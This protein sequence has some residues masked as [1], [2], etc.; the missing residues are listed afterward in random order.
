[1]CFILIFLSHLGCSRSLKSVVK[2]EQQIVVKTNERYL[3]LL[4]GHLPGGLS[5][6]RVPRLHLRRPRR[7]PPSAGWTPASA[8]CTADETRTSRFFQADRSE[9]DWADKWFARLTGMGAACRSL[10]WLAVDN[11]CNNP[12]PCVTQLE[13]WVEIAPWWQRG[14]AS[15]LVMFFGRNGPTLLQY[16]CERARCCGIK[17]FKIS[18]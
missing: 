11:S 9:F 8:R 12:A 7:A 6:G 15:W 1:M 2:A 17:L 13:N 14:V 3:A 18:I 16:G 10:G 5:K 4:V